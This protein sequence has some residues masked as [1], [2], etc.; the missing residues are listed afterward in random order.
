MNIGNYN[1]SHKLYWIPLIEITETAGFINELY[2]EA[3]CSR[4]LG[5][6]FFL[7]THTLTKN[8]LSNARGFRLK[9]QNW[10]NFEPLKYNTEKKNKFIY[11]YLNTIIWRYKFNLYVLLICFNVFQSCNFLALNRLYFEIHKW[12][13]IL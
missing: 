2:A 6:S 8:I 10:L 13:I 5:S 9:M 3:T 1:E 4:N 12:V 7:I 11:F